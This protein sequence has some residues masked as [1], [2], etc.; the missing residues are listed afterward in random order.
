MTV[1]WSTIIGSSFLSV[2]VWGAVL[3]VRAFLGR[4]IIQANAA[5]KLN[6]A[7]LELIKAAQ[8]DAESAGREAGEARREAADARREAT[9]A[10][11]SAEDAAR[12]VRMIKAAILSPMATIENL[13]AM[14]GEPGA[15][16][17]HKVHSDPR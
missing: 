8:H 9:D 3:I 2:L 16:G 6:A 1:T 15:N 14:I 13:R 5:V 17:V 4:P 7:A 10:R 12:E 11:R